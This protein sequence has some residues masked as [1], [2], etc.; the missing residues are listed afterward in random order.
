LRACGGA[1]RREP[2]LGFKNIALLKPVSLSPNSAGD[3]FSTALVDGATDDTNWN[4]SPHWDSE[5]LFQCSTAFATIDLGYQ[6]LLSSITV[7][8]VYSDS[9]RY[10]GQKLEVSNVPDFEGE[11]TVVVDNGSDF[12]SEQ[13]NI[14]SVYGEHVGVYR[15]VRFTSGRSS[16][17]SGIEMVEVQVMGRELKDADVTMAKQMTQL[18]QGPQKYLLH[19]LWQSSP[20]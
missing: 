14:G 7:W 13:K 2:S 16:M 19:S 6:S 5:D 18:L 8:Q 10:C 11:Q 12:G 4:V 17:G 9:R 20:Q 3:G 15:Y 1:E